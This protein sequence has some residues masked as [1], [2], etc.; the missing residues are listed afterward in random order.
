MSGNERAVA[1]CRLE[2]KTIVNEIA[3][4]LG[5]DMGEFKATKKVIEDN[6]KKIIKSQ[7]A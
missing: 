5:I 3:P 1:A 2:I 4:L 7:S 6:F